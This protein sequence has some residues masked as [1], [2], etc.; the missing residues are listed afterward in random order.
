MVWLS[1][2]GNNCKI[3]SV[4]WT[5]HFQGPEQNVA[6]NYETQKMTVVKLIQNAWYCHQLDNLAIYIDTKLSFI[7]P[8]NQRYV[9]AIHDRMVDHQIYQWCSSHNVY[10]CMLIM[11]F[12]IT[13]FIIV[14][15]TE[16][17]QWYS[18]YLLSENGKCKGVFSKHNVN[19]YYN[20]TTTTITCIAPLT[21]MYI[22]IMI[23]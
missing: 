21:D 20:D 5:P 12:V 19:Q 8:L 4:N 23:N 16:D 15:V 2:T 10:I 17:W 22:I 9:A 1:N 18:N 6:Y 14:L 13:Q 11:H 3:H 7:W